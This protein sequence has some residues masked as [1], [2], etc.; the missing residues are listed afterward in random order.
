MYFHLNFRIISLISNKKAKALDFNW[1]SFKVINQLGRIDILTV[2]D[3]PIDEHGIYL[4]IF[5]SSS[6]SLSNML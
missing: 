5:Q 1:D 3:L 6:I 2:S 4:H